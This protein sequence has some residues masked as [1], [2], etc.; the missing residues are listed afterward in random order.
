M[1]SKKKRRDTKPFSEA[2][3]FL[4]DILNLFGPNLYIPTDQI[5]WVFQQFRVAIDNVFKNNSAAANDKL[6]VKDWG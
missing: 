6:S 3:L 2:A 5:C 1:Y 4:T